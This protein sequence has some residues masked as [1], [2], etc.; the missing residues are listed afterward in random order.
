MEVGQRLRWGLS[1]FEDKTISMSNKHLLGAAVYHHTES[2]SRL[3]RYTKAN[4][5]QPLLLRL[6]K[7]FTQLSTTDV[8]HNYLNSD[9]VCITNGIDP[10]T[11]QKSLGERLQMAGVSE[12]S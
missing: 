5:R 9:Q 10:W 7:T 3:S 1:K 2:E 6:I 11:Q 4:P 12:G 8:V